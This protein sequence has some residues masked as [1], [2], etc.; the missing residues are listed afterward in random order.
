MGF[1]EWKEE[2][3]KVD[4]VI[5]DAL[6][7]FVL[8][9]GVIALRNSNEKIRE[10]ADLPERFGHEVYQTARDMARDLSE[11]EILRLIRAF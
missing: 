5:R 6:F 9:F 11:G 8:D 1:E 7:N 10:G 3:E 2:L 4:S